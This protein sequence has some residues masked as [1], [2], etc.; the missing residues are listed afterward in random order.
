MFSLQNFKDLERA[1]MLSFMI[2]L[3]PNI[4]A[5]FQ[6]LTETYFDLYKKNK[7]LPTRKFEH[8]WNNLK[9]LLNLC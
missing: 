8:F 4:K 3:E 2:Y 7:N 6:L 5:K 1:S 9:T